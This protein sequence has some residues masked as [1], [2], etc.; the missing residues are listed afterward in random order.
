MEQEI[1]EVRLQNLAL[2]CPP[3]TKQVFAELP[4]HSP[5]VSFFVP[6]KLLQLLSVLP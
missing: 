6:A 1:R 4:L 2:N 5:T 3:P